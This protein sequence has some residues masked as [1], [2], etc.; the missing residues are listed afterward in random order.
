MVLTTRPNIFKIKTETDS[1]RF[2]RNR[3]FA[4]MNPIF[5]FII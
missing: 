1:E 5:E 2:Y 4:R 3:I